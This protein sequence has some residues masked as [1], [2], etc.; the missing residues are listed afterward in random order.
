MASAADPRWNP[1]ANDRNTLELFRKRCRG[2]ADEMTCA[3]QA[4]EVLAERLRPGETLLDAGC[5]GGHYVH[6]L[7]SRGVE[8]EYHGLDYTP[9]MIALA[10]AELCPR[11]GLPESRFELAAIEG[12]DARYDT[13]LCF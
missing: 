1:W 5:A 7:R 3:A 13:V 10:H 2:E 9:E 6:S 12:L 11:T 4:A 8:V